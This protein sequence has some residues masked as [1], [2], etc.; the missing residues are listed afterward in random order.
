MKNFLKNF[1]ENKKKTLLGVGPMSKNCVDACCE[2]ASPTIPLMLIASRRQIDSEEFG[3]GYVQNWTTSDFSKYVLKKNKNIILCRDHGGPWQNNLEIENKLNLRD[4]MKSAK[5]SYQRDIDNNFKIIHI[6]TSINYSKKKL[7]LKESLNRLFELIIFCHDYA[8]KKNK[9]ILFEVGTE[10]QSGTTN[11]FEEID[12]FLN[13]ITNFCKKEKLEKPAFIVLQTGTKVMEMENVGS[14]ESDLRIKYEI[15]PEIQI[16]K[17]LE[18]CK[19]YGIWMKEHNGD[20]LSN[21]SLKWHPLLGI[22]AV[23]VAPEFGVEETKKFIEILNFYNLKKI[24]EQ[25]LNLSYSSNKWKKWLKENS[26]AT[27]FEKSIISGHYVFS[28]PKF[29]EIKKQA[30]KTLKNKKINID[31]I[32]RL[33]VK[34]KIIRYL[35]HF[36]LTN[37]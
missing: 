10:E 18:L 37:K 36:K 19:K 11:T 28:D 8:Q 32:L 30:Q 4:A 24:K 29:Y 20:Y 22:H 34:S 21:E 23:N 5:I 35:E 27:D 2:I 12:F 15:P 33:H 14:F 1:I 9:K 6:D 17:V 7:T 31:K 26:K 3:G 16:F 25:F 13:Q